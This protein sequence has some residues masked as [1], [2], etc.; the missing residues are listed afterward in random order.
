MLLLDAIENQD[1]TA[2]AIL[3]TVF[4]A[5]HEDGSKA[6]VEDRESIKIEMHCPLIWAIRGAI[7]DVPPSILSRGFQIHMQKATPRIKRKRR[8]D[9][10]FFEDLDIAREEIERWAATCT[11]DFDPDI[12]AELGSDS[13]IADA[14]LA[15]LSIADSLG[16]GTEARAA[17]IELHAARPPQDD[18]VQLL[19]DIKLVFEALE[20]DR[21]PQKLLLKEVLQRGHPMWGQ[22]RGLK[23]RDTPHD[24]RSGEFNGLLERF[25]IYLKTVWPKGPRGPGVKSY[26]G[27]T[28]EQFEQAWAAHCPDHTSAQVRRI[29]ALAKP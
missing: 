28:I 23:G 26:P 2:N 9:P 16:H 12:P 14:A 8:D 20:V 18:G 6:L 15:L 21:I 24:L 7:R 27:F 5:C 25:H 22:Y 17:L 11:L 19:I 29:I 3:W 4:D 13:R 1:L 10:A